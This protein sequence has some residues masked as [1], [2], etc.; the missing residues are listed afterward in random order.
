LRGVLSRVFS[1]DINAILPAAARATWVTAG[2]GVVQHS[3][4]AVAWLDSAGIALSEW[5]EIGTPDLCP[6][7]VPFEDGELGWIEDLILPPFESEPPTNAATLG[8]RL[9]GLGEFSVSLGQVREHRPLPDPQPDIIGCAGAEFTIFLVAERFA[10]RE[11]F[12]VKAVELFDFIRGH[13]PFGA[14]FSSG[15]LAASLLFWSSDN[16][17]GLFGTFDPY[18]DASERRFLGDNV[19]ARAALL[20]WIGKSG[21]VLVLINSEARGG[22]GGNQH[23]PAWAS[24]G[25]ADWKQ[26]G[27]HE[28]GHSM[29]L[30]DEYVAKG[31]SEVAYQGE[32]NVSAEMTPSRTCWK[33]L[34]NVGDVPAPS[35]SIGQQGGA[36]P[37]EIGT[38]QGAFYS[39]DWCR[40]TVNCIMRATRAGLEFCPVCKLEIGAKLGV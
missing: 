1:I 39:D 26:V 11:A 24:T 10:D 6:L 2:N 5:V 36:L 29:G 13:E 21:R 28:L 34:V 40:P 4:A 7:E 14:A 35:Y 27:L 33:A 8:M 18:S 38:F 37:S 15:R 32:P 17:T 31:P 23:Y 12:R 30:A 9:D 19:A 20:P 16:P 3:R 25:G 22:A